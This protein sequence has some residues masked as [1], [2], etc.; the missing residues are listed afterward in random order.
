MVL[1]LRLRRLLVG[2]TPLAGAIAF[3]VIVPLLMVRVGL[4]AGLLA[5]VVI[6]SLWFVSMLVS[7]EMPHEG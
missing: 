5:A 1:N 6:G 7:A 4:A 2:G 3:P